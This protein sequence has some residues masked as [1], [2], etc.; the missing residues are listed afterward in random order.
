M[1]FAPPNRT[2]HF[3]DSRALTSAVH[4]PANAFE[5]FGRCWSSLF[6][7]FMSALLGIMLDP[8]Q[9]AASASGMR[10]LPADTEAR[11][12]PQQCACGGS[13]HHFQNYLQ[14]R[15]GM[16]LFAWSRPVRS[17]SMLR[18]SQKG[19]SLQGYHS[20]GLPLAFMGMAKGVLGLAVRPAVG[21][22]EL[23][24]KG[25]HGMGMVC[26]GREAITGSAQRRVRAPGAPSEEQTEASNP[27][28]ERF[29]PLLV[30]STCC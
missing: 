14:E 5:A 18:E 24:S 1:T 22:L 27:L 6:D 3:S 4:R 17:V 23:V 7:S 13:T 15:E 21:I 12:L 10:R 26:L 2:G 9:V 20:G 28:W 29:R 8:T 19:A 16:L 11:G 30:W 25:T